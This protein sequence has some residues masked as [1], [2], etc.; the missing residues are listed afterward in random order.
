M[1]TQV[2][3]GAK[4][5]GDWSQD[6]LPASKYSLKAPNSMKPVGICLHN[7]ANSVPAANEIS[8]MKGNSSSTSYHIAVDENRAIQA[9]PFDRNGWH[10]GDGS[11]G[12]GNRKHIGIEI[13]RSTNYNGNLFQRSE[14]RAAA[15]CAKLCGQYGWGVSQIKAHRD[16]SG[17]NCPHRTSMDSFRNLVKSAMGGGSAKPAAESKPA[18]SSGGSVSVGSKVQITGST[19]ATGQSVPAWVKS[20]THVVSEIKGNRA[21]LGASGGIASWVLLS[22]LR[23]AGGAAPTPA[24]KPA[25]KPAVTPSSSGGAVTVGAKV[26]ITGSTYATGQNIPTWVK[27]STHVVSE[28][29]DGKALLGASGGICSWVLVKNLSVA[30]SAPAPK[31]AP[32]PAPKPAD[33]P[34]TGL[35]GLLKQNP[36]VKT[37]QDLIN[38]FYKMGGNNFTQASNVA[39][40]YGVDLNALVANRAGKVAQAPTSSSSAGAIVTGAKVNITGSKYASGQSIPAW[41]KAT[42][43]VVSEIKG[44]RALLGASGGICSW[45]FLRDLKSAGA[46]SSSTTKPQEPKKEEPK[47]EAPKKEEPKPASGTDKEKKEYAD[48]LAALAKYPGGKLS[49]GEFVSLFGPVVREDNRKTGVPAAVS[50]AQAILETG[51]GQSTIAN[52]K[53]LF[54]IKGTGPAGTTISETWEVYDGKKVNIKAGFRVYNTWLESVEDHSKFL[55]VNSRYKNAFNTKDSDSFAREIHKAGYATDPEY[56]NKLISLMNQYNLKAWDVGKSTTTKPSTPA[57][58]SDGGTL[59]E[60]LS[61]N[62]HVKTNQDLINVFFKMGGNDYGTASSVARKYGVDM[63]ALVANRSGNVDGSSSKNTETPG[64]TSSPTG[65][66]Q[67][68]STREVARR[69]T[70][71]KSKKVVDLTTKKTF[72]VSWDSS[73]GYHTDFTPMAVSDT[74]VIKSFLS[75]KSPTDKAYWGN[76]D[77]WSWNARPAAI[78]LKDGTWV[79][80][81]YHTRPHAA[82]MGGNPGHPFTNQSN[83]RPSGGWALGGHMCMYYGDSPGGTPKCNDAAKNASKMKL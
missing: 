50:L 70:G 1:S 29:K 38:V 49:P 73:P 48:S 25:P 45:V 19:Y 36:Q 61:K 28:I 64:K 8:Y 67:L 58:S 33:K 54:G 44:D 2:N 60:L 12:P 35:A 16:F 22:D 41:V 4:V 6:M 15:V 78:Q 9:L 77:N 30:G 20:G 55:T 31:P 13:A 76:K 75:S 40:G 66:I 21:L 46:G 23:V 34:V 71:R 47:K 18:V 83:T 63:N 24:P 42:S 68:M 82:I 51:W 37:N 27:N 81:G 3:V 65:S 74:T 59:K 5:S 72:N 80:C 79:A 57:P 7:T 62:P 43:H 10:A 26:K 53:N 11:N 32:A 39:R 69:E 14:Q 56:S 52:A 17:K